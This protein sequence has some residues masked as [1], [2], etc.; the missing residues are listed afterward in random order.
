MIGVSDAP[1]AGDRA[2]AWRQ[3][4][5]G[6]GSV[7][8]P[9]ACAV[10]RA[11]IGSS[12]D[13]I[14]CHTC[15]ARLVP[16]GDPRCARCGH[17]RL[18][19]SAPL[20]AGASSTGAPDQL[21]PCRWCDR[22]PMYV[23]AVRSV[24]RMDDG[25]G[26]SMVHALKYDGW[27]G[28]ASAM[29]RR[30]ARVDF[31]D[32]VVRERTALVPLPLSTTR[33]RER[34]YNQAE[35][36]ATALAAHWRLPVWCDVVRRTRDTKSQ[37][38]LTPSERTGNVLHAFTAIDSAATRLHGAHVVLV[39]DV[40]TTAATLNAASRALTDG[41]A[42]IISYITFGRAPDPGD[43]TDIDLDSDQD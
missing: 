27:R 15:L 30:M 43:R 3:L 35:C 25:S 13:S 1:R 24:C 14:V 8:L 42:R 33:E 6:L 36:L 9:P 28:V 39:D 5:S 11:A 2:K 38:R 20:P 16:L 31:P 21:P 23:R 17:P 40:I 12:A 19:Q 26:A 41:G 34:G 37:V 22:L 18:S 7:L 4:A 32:D 10:C 29:A